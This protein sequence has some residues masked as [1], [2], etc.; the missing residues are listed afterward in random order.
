M[1]PV[2]ESIKTAGLLVLLISSVLNI[3]KVLPA[4]EK[5]LSIVGVIGVS[6]A[7]FAVLKGKQEIV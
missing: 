7:L 4:F 6:L 2:M 1:N 5:E 3:L